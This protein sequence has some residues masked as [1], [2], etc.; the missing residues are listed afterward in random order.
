M[1]AVLFLGLILTT[2]AKPS[3][4]DFSRSMEIEIIDREVQRRHDTA[5]YTRGQLTTAQRLVG[6]P[7]SKPGSVE[8]IAADLKSQEAREAEMTALL[9]LRVYERDTLRKVE[10]GD[11]AKAYR[12]LLDWIRARCVVAKIDLERRTEALEQAQ[13]IA[14]RKET[15]RIGVEDAELAYR[16]ALAGVAEIEMREAQVLEDQAAAKEGTAR[17]AKEIERLAGESR[18]A[19]LHSLEIV[20]VNAERRLRSPVIG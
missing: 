11:D 18:K 20:A 3:P 6:R 9:T 17:D 5:L 8:R 4:L 2:Q 13:A 19:R 1:S 12:L 16:V 10:T 15:T 14:Q 7:G